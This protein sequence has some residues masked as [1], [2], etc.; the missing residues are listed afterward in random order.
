MSTADGPEDYGLIGT[1]LTT[2]GDTSPA[3]ALAITRFPQTGTFRYS[4]VIW[5]SDEVARAHCGPTTRW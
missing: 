1:S 2:R 3:C 5:V 4:R